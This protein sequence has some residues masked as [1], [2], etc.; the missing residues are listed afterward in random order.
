MLRV[1][2]LIA[3]TVIDTLIVGAIEA[4]VDAAPPAPPAIETSRTVQD[5]TV[6]GAI[7]ARGAGTAVA[8]PGPPET[9]LDPT[10]PD[11]G[12]SRVGHALT[13]VGP[14]VTRVAETIV[15]GITE[16]PPPTPPPKPG[17]PRPAQLSGVYLAVGTRAEVAKAT[18]FDTPAPMLPGFGMPRMEQ[19]GLL[20]ESAV[21]VS[22]DEG[23]TPPT[24]FLIILIFFWNCSIPAV[25][26]SLPFTTGD[27][28]SFP[29]IVFVSSF[30]A[31]T[32]G[33]F[34]TW[35]PWA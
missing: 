32:S 10:P 14:I 21:T 12:T 28:A 20:T 26:L 5:L 31:E 3:G 24:L 22:G 6:N 29:A 2:V 1:I 23:R 18:E 16:L 33:A 25:G 13:T 19:E 35:P 7:V 17:A 11:I 30:F 27:V 34:G 15:V 9:V 8:G 4:G